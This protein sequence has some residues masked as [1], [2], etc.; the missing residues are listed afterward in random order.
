MILAFST[1]KKNFS[2]PCKAAT[3][4]GGLRIISAAL[5]L[6]IL[7]KGTCHFFGMFGKKRQHKGRCL[8][9]LEC[10]LGGVLSVVTFVLSVDQLDFAR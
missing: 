6:A 9:P 8:C 3:L 7:E 10:H 5:A 4:Q 1:W 2:S